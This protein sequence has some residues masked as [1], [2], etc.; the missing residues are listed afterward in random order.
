[1][2]AAAGIGEA[3]LRLRLLFDYPPPGS[4]ACGL[5]WLLLEP[6]QVR[7]VTDIISLI[8][9][10]FGFSRHSQLS[11]FLD[12]ALLPPTESAR[13]VRDNDS[14]RVKLE[15]VVRED[16]YN[17]FTNGFSNLSKKQRKRHWQTLEAKESE[18]EDG[19]YQK[20][21]RKQ[22]AEHLSSQ[23]E[24]CTNIED[25]ATLRKRKKV[26]TTGSKTDNTSNSKKLKKQA[27]KEKKQ[28]AERDKR[29]T[30]TRVLKTKGTSQ[31]TKTFILSPRHKSTT[32]NTKANSSTKK[33]GTSS[34]SSTSSSD[35]DHSN[36][37]AKQ[38]PTPK[39]KVASEPIDK[40]QLA[41]VKSICADKP[42][43]KCQNT[44]SLNKTQ[45]KM[46]KSQSSSSDSDSSSG[47][48]GEQQNSNLKN[49]LPH[50][51]QGTVT[52]LTSKTK[53][54]TSSDS[55]SSESETC[56]KKPKTNAIV[57]PSFAENSGK[58]LPA[59]IY[60]PTTN[61]SNSQRG[62]G[63]GEN[64]FWR[65]PRIR[66]CRG[67]IRGRGRGR[68][69]NANYFYNYN[70]EHQKQQ[71]LNETAT[72]TSVIIQ[73]PLEAPKK[74]YSILPL[75]AAPPQVGEKIAF[76][77]LEL[78]EN[79]TPEV[80]DYKEG[81]IVSWNP[82][83]KQLELEILSFSSVTK[84]PGKFDLVYQSADGAETIEYAVS[85][86]RKI[87]QSW[88]ALIEPR[89]IVEPP[90]SQPSPKNGNPSDVTLCVPCVNSL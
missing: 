48:L 6:S 15:E 49:K 72:N 54:K 39:T 53:P 30:K 32:E 2:A 73:N 88:D 47:E 19:K 9:H 26:V 50:N 3:P 1:M 24:S 82:A 74:D 69:E 66:G 86:D 43:A 62:R 59:G 87:T 81:K 71:Q 17:E 67:M 85:Q 65:G 52:A 33:D 58:Q 29:K 89:L 35:S 36:T 51:R 78:T 28:K 16:N 79:Y 70:S 41:S 60:G 25:S 64:P 13:L 8:R 80:S 46:V 11:L 84:E 20:R 55:D 77:L 38:K 63:R 40:S 44:N 23:A 7:L 4:P 76:K 45:S 42:A 61:L 22:N 34:D 27:N 5:C 90:N 83:N 75:L 21:K 12:G 10:K 68:G 37:G 56:I 31:K 14:L 57:S 18:S